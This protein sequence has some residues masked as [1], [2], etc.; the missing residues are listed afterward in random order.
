MLALDRVD[1]KIA[2]SMRRATTDP[3]AD[4]GS[5][6]QE[7]QTVPGT[8]TKLAPFGAFVRLEDG[9]E[10]LAHSSDLGNAA[11]HMVNEDDIGEFRILSI[12][13]ARR[14]IRLTPVEIY[15]PEEEDYESPEVEGE[16]AAVAENPDAAM[17]DDFEAVGDEE[18][19]AVGDEDLD[20]A[21]D[22]DSNAA[23]DEDLEAAAP[24]DAA[25]A[26]ESVDM[27]AK[28]EADGETTSSS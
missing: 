21:V 27:D 15:A 20:A 16:L 11:L 5:R 14:R 7:N 19:D 13:A 12:D 2:L 10:G 28:I 18:L 22:E 3:W 9:V 6:F 24:E 1:K 8:V 25:I 26:T 4:L 17:D 23:A